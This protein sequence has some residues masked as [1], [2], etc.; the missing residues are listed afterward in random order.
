M[1]SRAGARRPAEHRDEA[2]TPAAHRDGELVAR[3]IA[4]GNP[5]DYD[6]LIRRYQSDVRNWLRHLTGD[7]SRADDLAQETFIRAWKRLHTIGDGKKFKAWIMKIAYN[8]FLQSHRRQG[9]EARLADAL[10]REQLAAGSHV[11]AGGDAGVADLP[12]MLAALTEGERV[13]MILCYAYGMSHREITELT[14]MP[15][16]TVKSHI[17]R[18]AARIRE[19]FDL[20]GPD[21]G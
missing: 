6:E 16:G 2:R 5:A 8:M 21:H 19:R 15:L 1:G 12:R 18:G 9:R 13:A 7:P 14:G 10:G 4:T 3:A 20:G 17:R 11:T